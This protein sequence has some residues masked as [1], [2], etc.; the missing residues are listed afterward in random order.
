MASKIDLIRGSNEG[1]SLVEDYVI[2]KKRPAAL[3]KSTIVCAYPYQP[4]KSHIFHVKPTDKTMIL[5]EVVQFPG[6]IAI[7]EYSQ[8]KNAAAAL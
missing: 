3:K 4:Q 5:C 2:Q 7:V 6:G 8:R 1:F